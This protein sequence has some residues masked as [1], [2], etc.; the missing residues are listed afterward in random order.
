MRGRPQ[1]GTLQFLDFMFDT[2]LLVSLLAT[3]QPAGIKP[4]SSEG[5]G[6]ARGSLQERKH[7]EE[8]TLKIIHLVYSSSEHTNDKRPLTDMMFQFPAAGH[9]EKGVASMGLP[10]NDCTAE[11]PKSFAGR[12]FRF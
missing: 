4:T 10:G 5:V 12:L 9:R 1:G 2:S 6:V 3:S 11:T 8:K 7:V